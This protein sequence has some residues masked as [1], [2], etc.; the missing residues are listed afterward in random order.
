MNK[1]VPHA[2]NAINN[3]SFEGKQSHGLLHIGKV[4]YYVK[5]VSN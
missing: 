3:T 2:I 5:N 1:L 4:L